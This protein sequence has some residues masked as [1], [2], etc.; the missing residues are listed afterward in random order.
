MCSAA[1]AATEVRLCL[2]PGASRT[3]SLAS[4]FCFLARRGVAGAICPGLVGLGFALLPVQDG[5]AAEKHRKPAARPAAKS[6]AKPEGR[7]EVRPAARPE[8]RP[9]VGRGDSFQHGAQISLMDA[10]RGTLSRSPRIQI[11]QTKT[12]VSRGTALARSGAFDTRLV[13][14]GSHGSQRQEIL[15]PPTVEAAPAQA[16]IFPV[17]DL[18]TG[19]PIPNV[20]CLLNLEMQVYGDTAI[21]VDEAHG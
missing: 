15:R 17:T 14:N 20:G 3:S 4:R 2:R 9:E 10:V 16:T 8:G 21:E 11:E 18:T 7:P 1:S 6:E 12:E 5:M 19:D 13:G